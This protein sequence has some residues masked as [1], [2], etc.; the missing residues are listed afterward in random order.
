MF[1]DSDHEGDNISCRS[2]IGFLTFLN[3]ALVK[4]FSRKKFTVWISVIGPAF[5][6]KKQ[7]IDVLR[8]I[9]YKLWMMH[10]PI[11]GSSYIYGDNMLV[12]HNTSRLE[13]LENQC[14]SGSL[15][16]SQSFR[17][18]SLVLHLLQ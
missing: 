13:L 5:V 16:R 18:Q 1:V 9:W 8:S 6:A 11:S 10:I 14:K 2:R 17:Y 4:W 7:D 15:R 3:T 12:V